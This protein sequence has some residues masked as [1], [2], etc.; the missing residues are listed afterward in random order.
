MTAFTAGALALQFVRL[1]VARLCRD[2]LA[3]GDRADELF[4]EINKLP[5]NAVAIVLAIATIVAL[6]VADDG[7][8]HK[9]RKVLLPTALVAVGLGMILI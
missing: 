7:K 5:L 8:C 4:H 9:C 3:R 1:L 2:A 6:L